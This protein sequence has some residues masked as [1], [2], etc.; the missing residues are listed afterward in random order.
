MPQAATPGKEYRVVEYIIDVVVQIFTNRTSRRSLALGIVGGALTALAAKPGPRGASAR[1]QTACARLG[2]RC[3][4]D[5]PCCAGAVCA[6]NRCQAQDQSAICGDRRVD[7]ATDQARC[8][9]CDRAC[10]EGEACTAGLCVFAW[11]VP[12]N[13]EVGGSSPTGV[14]VAPD[15]TVVVADQVSPAIKLFA[16][17]GRFLKSWGDQGSGDGEVDTPLA[18]AVD[19]AGDVYVADALN[20][21]IQVFTGEG[22]F[23]RTIG[24]EL[25]AGAARVSAGCSGRR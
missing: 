4:E 17:D 21:R 16:P 24:D 1:V 18:V 12:G 8:G 13:E 19:R 3:R 6:A 9:R 11:I 20:H 22:E 23:K 2:H 14:A 15:R 10:A 5:R 7:L 25:G